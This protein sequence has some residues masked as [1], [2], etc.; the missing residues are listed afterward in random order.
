MDPTRTPFGNVVIFVSGTSSASSGRLS[1]IEAGRVGPIR[2]E[3]G[4]VYG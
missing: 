2:R 3:D 1:G 4:T